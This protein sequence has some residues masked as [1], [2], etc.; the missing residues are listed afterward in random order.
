MAARA[1]AWFADYGTDLSRAAAVDVAAYLETRPR[2]WASRNLVRAAL[3]HYWAWCQRPDP[4]ISALR[5]PLSG[6]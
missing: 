4:P 3:R 2:T 6:L 5:V 1:E